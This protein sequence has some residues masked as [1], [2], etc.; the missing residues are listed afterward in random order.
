MNKQMFIF[1]YKYHI[2][3]MCPYVAIF[4]QLEHSRVHNDSNNRTAAVVK[5]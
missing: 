5:L 3:I 2:W 4:F 1:V